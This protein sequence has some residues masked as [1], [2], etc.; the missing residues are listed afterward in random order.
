MSEVGYILQGY[1]P[2][3]I[4]LSIIALGWWTT[5]AIT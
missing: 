3:I 5:G 2:K 4:D 1:G